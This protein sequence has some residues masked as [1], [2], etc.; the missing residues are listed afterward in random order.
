[1]DPAF[2]QGVFEPLT[3]LPPAVF[4]ALLGLGAAIENVFP[5][6]PAD[7]FVLF[8]AFLAAGGRAEPALVFAATWLPNVGSALVVYGLAYR[9]GRAA[10]GTTVGRWLLQP[11]QLD[12]IADFYGRWGTPAIFVSRFLPAFR[13]V[14]PV[15]AG[16]SHVRPAKVILPLAAASALW[17]G[18]LVYIGT[19]AGRNWRAILELVGRVNNVLI[20]FALLVLALIV[21]WWWRT[22]RGGG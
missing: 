5:P 9:Y 1:M 18:V 6:I 12:Q 11:R 3:R 7:T 22:R 10:F 17:Y 16:I 15:F 4:Y 13:A 20:G 8:G 19:T 14:V 21:V 2:V